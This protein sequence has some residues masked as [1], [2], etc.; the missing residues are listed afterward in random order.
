ARKISKYEGTFDSSAFR[1]IRHGEQGD[2][3]ASYELKVLD[4]ADL[5]S[6]LFGFKEADFKPEMIDAAIEAAKSVM[7]N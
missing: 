3:D 6:R 7:N 4:D 5:V 2:I 1:A